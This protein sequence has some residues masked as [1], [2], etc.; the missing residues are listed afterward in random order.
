MYYRMNSR[1]TSPGKKSKTDM[2][3]YLG[4]KSYFERLPV[5]HKHYSFN[6]L[7]ITNIYTFWYFILIKKPQYTII[8]YILSVKYTILKNYRTCNNVTFF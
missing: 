6:V 5:V 3:Y 2:I 8:E 7:I 1:S 4:G